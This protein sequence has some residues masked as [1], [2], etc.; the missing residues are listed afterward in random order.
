[1]LAA[2]LLLALSGT[3]APCTP[4]EGAARLLAAPERRAF[5]FGE[6]HG[7]T[8]I[9]DLF[10]DLVCQAAAS[11]PIVVGLEVPE[12]SQSAFDAWLASDGAAEARAALLREPFWRFTDGRASAAMLALL[13]RLRAMRAAGRRISL[14]AFVPPAGRAV[15]QTPYEQ[16]IAASWRRALAAA[17]GARLLVLV[18]SVHSRIAGYLDFEPAAMHLPRAL[19][20][21]FGPFPVG[22]TAHNCQPAGC[23]PHSAGPAPRTIP[24]RGLIPAPPEGRAA[25]SYDYLYSPGTSFT[26]SPPAVA[27]AGATRSRPRAPRECSP[28]RP[29]G[30]GVPHTIAVPWRRCSR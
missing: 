17:P 25:M 21:T 10:G 24:P 13:K 7:T 2:A 30:R 22:G 3:A 26:P 15:T 28:L 6:L 19:T 20:L 8:Q 1:M 29:G 16:A 11:G 14:L 27:T 18:G 5:I 23:G 4:V 12:A 9:P